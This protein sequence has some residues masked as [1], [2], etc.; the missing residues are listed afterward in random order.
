[1]T[2]PWLDHLIGWSFPVG[3]R[4]GAHGPWGYSCRRSGHRVTHPERNISGRTSALPQKSTS[5]LERYLAS[6]S[7]GP[8]VVFSF[9]RLR[10]PR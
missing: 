5:I 7:A 8:T 1:M 3:R 6:T 10:R 9:S 4:L 2:R